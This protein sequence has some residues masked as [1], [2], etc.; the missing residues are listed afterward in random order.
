MKTVYETTAMLTNTRSEKGVEAEIDN[1]RETNKGLPESLDAF[2]ANQK[3]HMR[4]NG[5]IYVGNA[6]GMEFTTPGPKS[7]N[8]KEG[9]Y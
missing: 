9:R 7:R 1:V 8:I 3:I 5:K 4:W 2:L 6:H